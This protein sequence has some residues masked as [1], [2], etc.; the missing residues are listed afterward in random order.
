M[1]AKKE[2]AIL[3]SALMVGGMLAG[4]SSKEE[5]PK[6]EAKTEQQQVATTKDEYTFDNNDYYTSIE[7]LK[8]NMGKDDK[9]VLIDARGE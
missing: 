1:K 6:E 9:L 2:I 4:C 7:W 8:E 3:L 5:K